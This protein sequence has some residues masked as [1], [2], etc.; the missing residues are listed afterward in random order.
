M[1]ALLALLLLAPLTLAQEAPAAP[2]AEPPRLAPVDPMPGEKLPEGAAWQVTASGLRWAVLAKGD[3]TQARPG[4]SDRVK[5][6]YAG[7]LENGTKFDERPRSG[8]PIEFGLNQV[9]AGWTE[10][11]QL[12]HPGSRVKL[13]IPWQIAYGAGGKPPKIPAKANLVFDIELIAV[14]PDPTPRFA[15]PADGELKATASGLKYQVISEGRADGRKPV[16]T[17]RVTVHYSGWLTDGTP[18]DSS[19]SRGQPASFPLNGV[20][21]GWTEGLQLMREGATYKFLIPAALGYGERGAGG[22]IPPNATLLFQ[23]ELIKV[24]T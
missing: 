4:P 20:I 15:L 23:V 22:V 14:T 18:F 2:A 6:H 13:H 7:W 10:G 17:D 16:A 11:L 9:I 8:P 24:G 19:Y 5:V 12:M 3:E 1:R 21:K